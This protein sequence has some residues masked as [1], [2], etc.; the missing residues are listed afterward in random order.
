MPDGRIGADGTLSVGVSSSRPYQIGWGAL[1]LAPWLELSLRYSRI[2]GV[3]AFSQN[4]TYGAYKDKSVGAKLRLLEESSWWPSIAIGTDDIVTDTPQRLFDSR[5]IAASKQFGNV[6]A[7]IGYGSGRIDGAFAGVRYLPSARSN[8]S[9][10]AEYDANDYR[11]DPFSDRTGLARLGKG[12]NIG[13][14]YDWGWFKTEAAY[15]RDRVAINAYAA[16]PL[17][18]REFVVKSDE[19]APYSRISRRPTEREWLDEEAHKREL[20]RALERQD[21]GAVRVQYANRRLQLSLTNSRISRV[22]RAIGRAARTAL[23]LSPGETREISI[24]YCIRDLALVTYEFVDLSLLQ[25]YFAGAAGRK[26]L[27]QSVGIRSPETGCESPSPVKSGARL[28]VRRARTHPAKHSAELSLPSA[29]TGSAPSTVTTVATASELRASDNGLKIEQSLFDRFRNPGELLDELED[30]D[31]VATL[32]LGNESGYIGLNVTDRTFNRFGV[33][34]A[35]ALYLNDPSGAV[36]YELSAVAGLERRLAPGLFVDAM[37]SVSLSQDLTSVTQLSNSRLPHVRTD[38]AEYARGARLKLTRAMVNYFS[39]LGRN[40]YSRMSVGLYEDMFGGAGGQILF[41]PRDSVQSWDIAVDWLKQRDFRGTGFR[42]YSVVTAL[43]SWHV[44]LPS[45]FTATAR[46]GRFLAKDHGVRF[47]LKRRFASGIEVGAWYSLTNAGDTTSP[48]SDSHPYR[49]KGIFMMVPLS[50][51]LTRDT[52]G[53]AGFS[54]SP[55]TRDVGQMVQSPTDLH[56]LLERPLQDTQAGD[57]M[58]EFGDDDEG[59]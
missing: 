44:Q 15:M 20:I 37:A 58:I 48:G 41:A 45:G 56:R 2:G 32:L 25:R 39:R 55:W 5:F 53:E 38:V 59:Y 40:T 50:S 46:I 10:Q 42:R 30:S 29:S 43:G 16:I 4:T 14:T 49:D 3:P 51:M 8:W 22:P 35:L 52:R 34:P 47:E 21:Y 27:G 26:A 11:R 57:G 19:P 23:L 24:T 54:L 17:E 9:F 31:T 7:T 28:D 12:V 33:W 1:A 6:D 13:V 18:K 36:H